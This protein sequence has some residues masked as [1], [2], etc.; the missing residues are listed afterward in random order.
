MQNIHDDPIIRRI[1][2]TGYAYPIPKE[3]LTCCNCNGVMWG[4]EV[5][6]SIDN[7]F[8]CESCFEDYIDQIP[9]EQIAHMLDI[10]KST[11]HDHFE[12]LKGD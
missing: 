3:N 12:R 5:Y 1:E 11:V 10:P 6:Y 7:D 4:D 2:T 8:Y 9:L